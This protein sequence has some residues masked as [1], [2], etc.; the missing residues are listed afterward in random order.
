MNLSDE[1]IEPTPPCCLFFSFHHIFIFS[2]HY[3]LVTSWDQKEDHTAPGV[4]RAGEHAD[5]VSY[6]LQ[7]LLRPKSDLGYTRW[8]LYHQ[9]QR[10]NR[11]R[12]LPGPRSPCR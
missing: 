9:N 6:A 4:I 12:P 7:P 8:D 3:Y 5:A 11:A 1:V 10:E 2:T